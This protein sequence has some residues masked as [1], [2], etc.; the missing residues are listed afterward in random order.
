[1]VV[2]A[3]HSH[4]SAMGVYVFPILKPLPP[5]S[6][7]HP[8]G[9]SQCTSPEHPVSCIEPNL[10]NKILVIVLMLCNIFLQL[11]YFIHNSLSF[12]SLPLTFLLST[13]TLVYSPFLWISVL[14]HSL[15]CVI[16]RFHL[17]VI[18]Y[19]TW[20]LDAKNWLIRKDPDAGKDWSL[21]EKKGTTE[22]EMVRWR[23]WLDGHEFEQAP[24]VGDGQG[25]LACCSPWGCKES[26]T[27]EWLN[28]TNTVFG[29]L[30]LIY[31]TKHNTSKSIHVVANDKILF[32]LWPSNIPLCIYVCVC[33]CVCITFSLSILLLMDI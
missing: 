30:C 7:S 3:I 18:V 10:K 29:F 28:G 8:S 32:F 20:Q 17:K 19:S 22:D 25:S 21:Q 26:D 4:E 9:S 12:N 31:I 16:F 23:H 2:F 14:L 1:M 15:F 5:P 33:V 24:G 6:P 11:I 13:G 27:T